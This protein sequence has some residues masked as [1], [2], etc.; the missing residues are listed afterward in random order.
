[1]HYH[2]AFDSC[3]IGESTKGGLNVNISSDYTR[4]AMLGGYMCAYVGNIATQDF[5]ANVNNHS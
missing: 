5:R 1:M 4:F 3:V 2:E